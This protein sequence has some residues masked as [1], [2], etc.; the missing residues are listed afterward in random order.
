MPIIHKIEESQKAHDLAKCD[1]I[2]GK[3]G[4]SILK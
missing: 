4:S 3:I 1:E 2:L